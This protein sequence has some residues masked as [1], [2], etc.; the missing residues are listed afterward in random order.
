MIEL[1]VTFLGKRGITHHDGKQEA[2]RGEKK[3]RDEFLSEEPP[4]WFIILFSLI[5][6]LRVYSFDHV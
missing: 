6:F 1:D 2:T 3:S 5:S 4:L